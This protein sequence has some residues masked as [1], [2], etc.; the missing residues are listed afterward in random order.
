MLIISENE[1]IHTDIC[2]DIIEHHGVKGMKWGQ[3]MQRWGSA[4]GGLLKRKIQH[5]RLYAKAYR[6]S[7]GMTGSVLSA[8][9]R[10][11]EYRNRVVDD[12][13]KANKQYKKDKK[14]ALGRHSEGDDKI[15]KKYGHDAF[16]TKRDKKGGESRQDYR[17]RQG[18]AQKKLANANVGLNT[19][20]KNDINK[21]KAKRAK[22][23]VNSGGK[24]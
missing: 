10:H 18:E 7:R 24:F 14:D 20:Y 23:Y 15:F 2:K 21:A 5:P 13:A 4:Y 16:F 17:V 12:M 8:T 1:L 22:A 6:K 3:R 9:T 11:M 19:R